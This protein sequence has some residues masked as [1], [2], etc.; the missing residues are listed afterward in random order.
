MTYKRRKKKVDIYQQVTERIIAAI[1]NSANLSWVKTWKS[2]NTE[3]MRLPYNIQSGKNYRGANMILTFCSEYSDSRWGTYKQWKSLN[4]Q[5]KKGEKS[6]PIIFWSRYTKEVNGEEETFCVA[7]SYAVFNADQ[8]EGE[9]PAIVEPKEDERIALNDIVEN[10]K[11]REN[12]RILFG[13]NKA[14]YSPSKDNIVIPSYE[15]FNNEKA[16]YSTI[17]H[18]IA[19]S[20]GHATRLN[21]EGVINNCKFGSHEYSKEELI[22]EFTSAFLMAYT[23]QEDDLSFKNSVAYLKSWS[24]KLKDNPTW[25]ISAAQKAQK[26]M[27]FILGLK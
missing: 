16:F 25:A 4:C 13:G 26:A 9:L 21:R 15:D 2:K 3:N 23:G 12:I 5:V 8:V 20:T 1:E 27:D 11:K 14:F 10:Y 17:Y 7:R 19:H 18:E 22:A 24:K 6:T